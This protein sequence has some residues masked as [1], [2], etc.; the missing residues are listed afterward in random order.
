LL[1][2]VCV[3]AE[4]ESVM[5]CPMT[6]GLFAFATKAGCFYRLKSICANDTRQSVESCDGNMGRSMCALYPTQVS[7]L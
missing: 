5:T 1:N 7:L 4:Y 6:Y 3:T 2:F